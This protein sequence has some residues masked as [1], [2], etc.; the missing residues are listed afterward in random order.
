MEIINATHHVLNFF[1]RESV[2]ETDKG[3]VLRDGEVCEKVI[4][5]L[6][7]LP[8]V[9]KE[10]PLDTVQNL[11][12]PVVRGVF[13]DIVGLPEPTEGVVYVTSQIV[14]K[15]AKEKGRTDVYYPEELVRDSEGRALGC[16]ALGH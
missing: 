14:A 9:E 5:P 15:A 13:G 16:L 8:R 11:D 12:V 4:V 1:L 3:Y 6:G 2:E 7:I 10:I